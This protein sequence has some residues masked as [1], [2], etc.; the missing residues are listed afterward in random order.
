M[1]RT[2]LNCFHFLHANVDFIFLIVK[3]QNHF[4][5]VAIFMIFAL[6]KLYIFK[7]FYNFTNKRV[8]G[9]AKDRSPMSFSDSSFVNLLGYDGLMPCGL[10]LLST[11]RLVRGI[12]KQ[13]LYVYTS[14]ISLFLVKNV[15][16]DVNIVHAQMHLNM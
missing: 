5:E 16:F 9:I 12:L 1:V 2:S 6:H 11:C 10:M 7:P 13:L 8:F 3:N 14:V 15:S 4:L